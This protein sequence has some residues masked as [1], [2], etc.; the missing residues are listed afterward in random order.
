MDARNA[1]LDEKL[2][3]GEDVDPAFM[4][5]SAL[6]ISILNAD[7]DEIE[8]AA[9][10]RVE[11]KI[12]ALPGVEDLSSVEHTLAVQHHVETEKG[13]VL[14]TVFDGST[15]A[16]FVMDTDEAIA[17]VN[18]HDTT[19]NVVF[20]TSLFST[21]TVTWG[22]ANQTVSYLYA[23]AAGTYA[24][25]FTDDGNS[26][27]T[28]YNTNNLYIMGADQ[29]PVAG[30]VKRSNSNGTATGDIY[31]VYTKQDGAEGDGTVSDADSSF[32]I[33]FRYNGRTYA[34]VTVHYVDQEGNNIRRTHIISFLSTHNVYFS[35]FSILWILFGLHK[36]NI[37]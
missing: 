23:T 7:G 32:H 5:F 28:S 24:W 16:S 27:Y 6:D 20:T 26:T 9:P 34:D 11:M 10:V 37:F 3:K 15:E 33:Y 13:V 21:F 36:H 2:S 30:G 14:E 12:K 25:Q 8:P 35:W 18:T 22:N 31:L 29:L 4:G 17:A 1:L 19:D